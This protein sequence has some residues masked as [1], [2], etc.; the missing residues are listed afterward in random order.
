MLQPAAEPVSS[1]VEVVGLTL[2]KSLPDARSIT[3]Q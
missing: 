2:T 3:I 1:A